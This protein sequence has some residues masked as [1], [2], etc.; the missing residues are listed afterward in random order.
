M[1]SVKSDDMYARQQVYRS[2]LEG[3]QDVTLSLNESFVVLI[4]ELCSLC[5]HVDVNVENLD[6]L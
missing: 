1:M 5:V 6:E 3:V 2:F 4:K